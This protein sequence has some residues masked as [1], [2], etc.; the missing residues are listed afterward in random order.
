MDLQ[1]AVV[2]DTSNPSELVHEDVEAI[3]PL[4]RI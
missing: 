3:A 1:P 4:E 2:F